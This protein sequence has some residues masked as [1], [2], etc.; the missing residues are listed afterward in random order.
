[1][2]ATG[3]APVHA[4]EQRSWR[5]VGGWVAWLVLFVLVAGVL[6][7]GGAS[8]GFAYDVEVS[9]PIANVLPLEQAPSDQLT[10]ASLRSTTAAPARCTYDAAA[11]AGP[12]AREII[13]AEVDSIRLSDVL[14]GPAPPSVEV[15]GT[16]TTPRCSLLP[17]EQHRPGMRT[18]WRSRR[19]LMTLYWAVAGAF[20]STE[21]T[22]LWMTRCGLTLASL[23]SSMS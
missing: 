23:P 12:A 15:R 3:G 20:T 2:G 1:M 7:L 5:D 4:P 16:S 6:Q 11:V 10:S 21:R 22:L 14:E 8:T 13:A 9:P 19:S 18:A 17:Q